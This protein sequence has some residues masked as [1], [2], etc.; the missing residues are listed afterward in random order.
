MS[1][2]DPY[3]VKKVNTCS[4]VSNVYTAI[5]LCTLLTASGTMLPRTEN[6]NKGK[7]HVH[8]LAEQTVTALLLC[9]KQT[10]LW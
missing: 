1:A 10:A 5:M 3:N 4:P 6:E 9:Y 8:L 2:F 7:V